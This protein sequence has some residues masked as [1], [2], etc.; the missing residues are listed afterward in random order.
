[1]SF[2]FSI[3]HPSAS[4]PRVTGSLFLTLTLVLLIGHYG[5]TA[6]AGADSV[7]FKN[8]IAPILL[9]HCQSCH[10]PRKAKGK[11][12][13]D[14]YSQLLKAGSSDVP[15]VSAGDLENSELVY[16]IST[17]DDDDRMPYD[18]EPLSAHQISLIKKWI[19]AGARNDTSDPTAALISII[20]PPRHPQPPFIYPQPVPVSALA[21]RPDGRELFA[22]GYHEITV[23][24]P[25][26][27]TLIRSISN[28]GQRTLGIDI[29]PDNRILAASGGMPGRLGEL[30]LFD[31]LSG[32][33]LKVPYQDA[34][35]ALDVAFS[36]DGKRLALACADGSVRLFDAPEFEQ[37]LVIQQHSDWIN[38]ICWNS[39]GTQLA[40]ASRDKSAKVFDPTS[41]HRLVTFSRHQGPVLGVAFHPL[42]TSL[43]SCSDDKTVA[44]WD[45]KNGKKQK[46]IFKA[47]DS[48]LRLI[49]AGESIFATS[50]EG[51]VNQFSIADQR[52]I[53]EFPGHKDWVIAA[54][55]H[56]LARRLATGAF[57]GTVI[58]WDIDSG[59]AVI[60]FKAA[61]GFNRKFHSTPLLSKRSSY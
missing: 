25:N 51:Q 13:V 32:E 40:T 42:G 28:Q 29:S 52:L 54:A 39:D 18:E 55:Y 47:G 20:P 57:D 36:P 1:M 61:P 50:A 22:S 7:S 16:R 24:S 27:G 30:R 15:G 46:E 45:R 44:Q 2:C 31:T 4:L 59:R 23:W 43:Y 41:G 33:L 14:S 6:Q 9:E 19:E 8:D 35:I 38:D 3:E 21:F 49:Q 5:T 58:V 48:V 56:S 26:E 11:Y 10:G 12:R 60:S 53:R 37:T 34:E 17:Q